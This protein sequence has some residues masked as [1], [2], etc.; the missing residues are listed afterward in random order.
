MHLTIEDGNVQITADVE[1]RNFNHRVTNFKVIVYDDFRMDWSNVTK[2]YHLNRKYYDK[3]EALLI[4]KYDDEFRK[5]NID[6][7]D[8]FESDDFP[9]GAA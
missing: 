8:K 1:M 3:A 5:L 6:C 2:D 7:R 4:E 9:K